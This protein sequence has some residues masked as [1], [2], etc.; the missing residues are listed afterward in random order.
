MG[1][2]EEV[3]ERYFLRLY[4]P[5]HA[6]L[7]ALRLSGIEVLLGTTNEDLPRLASSTAF[8]DEW[9]RTNVR[10]Y[11]PDV[12]V[13][14]VAVGN[15]VIPGQLRQATQNRQVNINPITTNESKPIIN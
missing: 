15:E 1:C 2:I 12:R 13:R 14:H 9:V 11:W 7:S 10:A 4:A 8:A 5:D 3:F 6:V